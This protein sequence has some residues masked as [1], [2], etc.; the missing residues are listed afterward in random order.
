MY[1]EH[2]CINIFNIINTELI[3]L[4]GS[5]IH[6]IHTWPMR[7][8]NVKLFK[9]MLFLFFFRWNCQTERAKEKTKFLRETRVILNVIISHL[10]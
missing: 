6:T 4:I 2:V 9:N 10:D 7:W 8:K 3:V 5:D 1:I